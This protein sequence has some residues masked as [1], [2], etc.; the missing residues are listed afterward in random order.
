[1][2]S[3]YVP[4]RLLS[5]TFLFT[6]FSFRD[7]GLDHLKWD[8][9]YKIIKVLSFIMKIGKETISTFVT[10]SCQSVLNILRNQSEI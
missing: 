9:L 8:T 10:Y 2:A 5:K 4:K 3:S 6:G 1:M 7:T